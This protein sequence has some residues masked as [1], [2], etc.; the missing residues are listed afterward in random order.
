MTEDELATLAP[1]TPRIDAED[2]S[3]LP[4]PDRSVKPS[5][6]LLHQLAELRETKVFDYNVRTSVKAG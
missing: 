2:E 5:P 3:W 6:A 1:P 4:Q